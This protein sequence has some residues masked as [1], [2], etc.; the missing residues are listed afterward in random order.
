MKLYVAAALL[1]GQAMWLI[2]QASPWA[3]VAASGLG[4]VALLV[5]VGVEAGEH[6]AALEEAKDRADW[7]DVME[8]RVAALESA[9]ETQKRQQAL[10]KLA[11]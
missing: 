1:Y 4:L 7:L 9:V 8:K 6:S 3:A 2:T 5:K 10:S 11:G